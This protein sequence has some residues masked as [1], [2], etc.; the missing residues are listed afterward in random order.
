MNKQK[1]NYNF[2]PNKIFLWICLIK[3]SVYWLIIDKLKHINCND[4]NIINFKP[5]MVPMNTLYE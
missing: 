3:T 1:K 4:A 2:N 5:P